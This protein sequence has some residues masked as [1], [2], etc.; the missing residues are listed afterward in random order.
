MRESG[1]DSVVLHFSP[2]FID[3]FAFAYR[4]REAVASYM[5]DEDGTKNV[6]VRLPRGGDR[7]ECYTIRVNPGGP[8]RFGPGFSVWSLLKIEPS[9][10]QIVPSVHFRGYLHAFVTLVEVP[11]PAP[12][13]A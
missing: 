13:E 3:G 2:K 10:W 1:G 11:D 5:V 4:G 7:F 8:P 12:W 9:T 6:F